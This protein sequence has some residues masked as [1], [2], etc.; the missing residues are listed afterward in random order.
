MMSKSEIC[1]EH[2]KS[3]NCAQSLLLT[4]A[5]ELQLDFT[6]AARLASGFGGGMNCGETCGAVTGAYFVI[7]LRHGHTS[8][9]PDAKAH[10]SALIR[11]FNRLFLQKH[12]SLKCRELTGFDLSNPE[13]KAAASEAGVFQTRCPAFLKTSCDILEK[14]F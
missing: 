14:Q 9:D 4:F 13:E 6:T 2:F 10:T 3:L 7:G 1:L 5:P 11:E 12:P 8:G